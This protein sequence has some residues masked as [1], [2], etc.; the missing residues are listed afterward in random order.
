MPVQ[1]SSFQIVAA[2][3]VTVPNARPREQRLPR[4]CYRGRS[5]HVSRH[6]RGRA[7]RVDDAVETARR[8]RIRRRRSCI[9]PGLPN[10]CASKHQALT[11]DRVARDEPRHTVVRP[12]PSTCRVDVGS[13]HVQIARAR[14]RPRRGSRV[15][16]SRDDRFVSDCCGPRAPVLMSPEA[17]L[18]QAAC[19]PRHGPDRRRGSDFLLVACHARTR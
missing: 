17:V 5:R 15:G 2:A 8:C 16:G 18:Q 6:H 1:E 13:G 9:S 11:A 3:R 7:W 4:D 10:I 12:Q 19:D 14:R